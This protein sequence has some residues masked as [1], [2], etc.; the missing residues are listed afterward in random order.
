MLTD[1]EVEALA[2]DLLQQT[3]DNIAVSARRPIGR[4]QI[5]TLPAGG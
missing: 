2:A 4:G 3:I 5:R 1:A